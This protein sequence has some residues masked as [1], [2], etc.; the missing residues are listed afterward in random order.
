MEAVVAQGPRRG[1]FVQMLLSALIE[2]CS[3]WNVFVA[4]L[5]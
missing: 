1:A 4:P 2:T 3:G 5:G